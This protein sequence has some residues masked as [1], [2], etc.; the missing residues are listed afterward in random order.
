[1]AGQP[2]LR[3]PVGQLQEGS[4]PIQTRVMSSLAISYRLGSLCGNFS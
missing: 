1:M 3:I 4:A 2:A